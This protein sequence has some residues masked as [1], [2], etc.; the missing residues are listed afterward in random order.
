MTYDDDDDFY[1]DEYYDDEWYNDEYYDDDEEITAQEDAELEAM[2]DDSDLAQFYQEF[3][4]ALDADII[5]LKQNGAFDQVY[6]ELQQ[7]YDDD[8]YEDDYYDG[9]Y[10]DDDEDDDYD[11]DYAEDYYEAAMMDEEMMKDFSALI[12]DYFDELDEFYYNNYELHDD[13]D[14]FQDM[15]FS[16][17]LQD[18][19][20][21]FAEE[22]GGQEWDLDDLNELDMNE[23]FEILDEEKFPLFKRM[24]DKFKKWKKKG[25]DFI[26][27]HK[28]KLKDKF[29][30]LKAKGKEL[31]KKGIEFHKK[32]QE[33]LK[34]IGIKA[35]AVAKGVGTAV[36]K[37]MDFYKKK[38]KE[39][40]G[41]G[42][43]LLG[44]G[45]AKW[46][47][48][49]KKLVERLAKW[50]AK[51]VALK[52]R[53]AGKVKAIEAKKKAVLIKKTA[54][55][56]KPI[57]KTPTK[58][59]K[60]PKPLTTKKKPLPYKKT[61]KPLPKMKKVLPKKKAKPLTIKKPTPPKTKVKKYN[62]E[63]SNMGKFIRK[64]GVE[65]YRKLSNNRVVK[66]ILKTYM[67]YLRT[68]AKR[69][70]WKTID[71]KLR[72]IL[73]ED[74][75]FPLENVKYATNINT[76]TGQPIT[77]GYDIF[78]PRSMNIKEDEYDLREMLKQL[79][80][81][82]TYKSSGGIWP[83]LE[84]Y[85]FNKDNPPQTKMLLRKCVRQRALNL[86]DIRSLDKKTDDDAESIL[87]RIWI[88]YKNYD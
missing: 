33:N 3:E 74:F 88:Q 25:K 71:I 4:D 45:K 38:G 73:A 1:D 47:A 5:R 39:L 28:K 53:C 32:A 36:K 57:K 79:E 76:I 7:Y 63:G 48:L 83:F 64:H 75:S 22:Y 56:V 35:K 43:K 54:P 60:K 26:D 81:A 27:Q 42:K 52:Q 66:A 46:E 15:D 10:Y 2:I 49:K 78:F 34:N 14:N 85:L 13:Y 44:G 68:A 12:N 20:D 50:K 30:K 41:K 24:K 65:G 87:Q 29:A 80:Y 19:L 55:K 70:G 9:D 72:N 21:D 23:L 67:F 51:F 31:I 59:I 40:I 11:E 16:Q 58:V 61:K 77:F 18:K 84:K 82:Q 6:D 17:V 37:K 69:Q 86:D 62:K 8:Y